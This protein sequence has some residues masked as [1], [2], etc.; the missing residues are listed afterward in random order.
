[1]AACRATPR[2]TAFSAVTKRAAQR[3]NRLCRRHQAHC[4]PAALTRRLVFWTT[5]K[6]SA[7]TVSTMRHLGA[8]DAHRHLIHGTPG[9]GPI[10]KTIYRCAGGSQVE[11]WY[12][13]ADTAR[14]RLSWAVNR[15]EICGF[16][17]RRALCRWRLGWGWWTK[18][19]KPCFCRVRGGGIASGRDNVHRCSITPIHSIL[20]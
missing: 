5:S 12:P 7:A 9:F 2:A 17:K 20:A 14:D 18:E 16:A 10:A 6:S 19:L 8:F 11:V 15:Y 1:M 4:R 3:C 13:T